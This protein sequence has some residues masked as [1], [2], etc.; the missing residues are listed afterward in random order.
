MPITE[1]QVTGVWGPREEEETAASS[2]CPSPSGVGET[3]AGGRGRGRVLTFLTHRHPGERSYPSQSYPSQPGRDP[4]RWGGGAGGVAWLRVRDLRLAA[5]GRRPY[6]D[7]ACGTHG[8]RMV[9][10]GGAA[11]TELSLA[12]HTPVERGSRTHT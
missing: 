9:A 11:L 5:R 4:Y 2:N 1:V 8:G 7:G 6:A 3:L 10:V 12:G